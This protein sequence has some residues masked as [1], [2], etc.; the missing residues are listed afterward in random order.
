MK[1]FVYEVGHCWDTQYLFHRSVL[2]HFQYSAVRWKSTRSE[3]YIAV[4]QCFRVFFFLLF[5]LVLQTRGNQITGYSITPWVPSTTSLVFPPVSQVC[6]KTW[7]MF[8]FSLS[9][10]DENCTTASGKVNNWR[11]L[12]FSFFWG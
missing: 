3:S 1:Y 8:W 4:W 11:C 12:W 7:W 6:V 9:I 10:S 5:W 2:K